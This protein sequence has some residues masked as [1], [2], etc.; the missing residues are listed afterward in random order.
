MVENAGFRL[1]VM[2]GFSAASSRLC[3]P[4]L[5]LITFSEVYDEAKNIKESISI[6]LI[7][8]A[9]NGYG[10][11]MNVRRTA[12][13]FIKLGCAGILIEDQVIPKRCGHTPG[14]EIVGREES[15]DRIKAVK[16]IREEFGDIVIIART[17]ANHTH[18]LNEAIVRGQEYY[19]LG[20]DIIF[21]EATKNINEMI[22]IC[23]QVPG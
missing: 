22:I 23:D 4:D 21:I 13:E 14:K 12:S 20:A 18:G 2:S 11:I 19:N 9:D 8:D 3:M 7:V 6:P 17:D 15:Y 10:N 1:T 16:D 5:G